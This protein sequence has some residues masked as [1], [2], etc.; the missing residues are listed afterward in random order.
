MSKTEFNSCSQ[1][2]P[3]L[4]HSGE[5]GLLTGLF[6]HLL[7]LVERFSL[8]QIPSW[9]KWAVDLLESTGQCQLTPAH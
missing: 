2:G 4:H 3:G 9:C 7:E 1:T 5:G 6:Q 8:A